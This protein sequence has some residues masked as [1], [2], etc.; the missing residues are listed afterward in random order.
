M[1]NNIF[2]Y[3]VWM[4]TFGS[5]LSAIAQDSIPTESP[6]I[7]I[8]ETKVKMVH[9]RDTV[10][11]FQSDSTI[12]SSLQTLNEKINAIGELQGLTLEQ[13]KLLEG[14]GNDNWR[15][16]KWVIG[17]G[18]ILILTLGICLSS[19][20]RMERRYFMSSSKFISLSS[21]GGQVHRS[22]VCIRM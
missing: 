14:N 13:Q 6:Q 17:I 22:H 12:L 18:L 15:M 19:Y 9:V 2:V 16:L 10:V 20:F 8:R 1:K 5:S 7:I 3:L 4:L 11:I 21:I